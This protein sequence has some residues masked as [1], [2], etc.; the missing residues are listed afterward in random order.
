MQ[1]KTFFGFKEVLETEKS[2][3]VKQVF[4]SVAGK[5]DI[6]NDLM[7]LGIHRI[8]KQKLVNMINVNDNDV[9]ID[10]AGGTA[11]ISILLH[12]KIVKAQKHAHILTCDINSDMLKYGQAKVIDAGILKGID[13]ITCDAQSLPFADQS[14]DIYV[15]AFGIRNVPSIEKALLEAR[16]VLKPG[17][18]FLCLEFTPLS[19]PIYD[20]YSFNIIPKIGKFISGDE[21]AYKYLVES[22]KKFPS[23]ERFASMIRESGFKNVT[24]NHFFSKIVAIHQGN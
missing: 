7:S 4:S 22:I 17:G 16:R 20:F 3:L 10:M 13:F 18:K 14:A 1:N 8:W 11:D 5:Y 15:I 24:F 12:Q 2:S 9:I 19:N 21:N 23:Q 6:M